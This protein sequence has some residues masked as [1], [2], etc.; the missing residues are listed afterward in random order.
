MCDSHYGILARVRDGLPSEFEATARDAA[1]HGPEIVGPLMLIVRDSPDPLAQLCAIKALAMSKVPLAAEG[2]RRARVLPTERYHPAVVSVLLWSP[3]R[4]TRDCTPSL[5]GRRT[6]VGDTNAD[7]LGPT[8]QRDAYAFFERAGLIPRPPV[9]WALAEE[10]LDLIAQLV[11]LR[12][13]HGERTEQYL[14]GLSRLN[15]LDWQ[16]KIASR[17]FAQQA[18]DIWKSEEEYQKYGREI[19]AVAVGV[20]DEYEDQDEI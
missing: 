13:E 7:V 20:E 18:G 1:G 10:R 11:R 16:I 12:A 14:N 9:A 15:E 3:E 4:I 5:L 8:P 17:A 2:L 6:P 19:D